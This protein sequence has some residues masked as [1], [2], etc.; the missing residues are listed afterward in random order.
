MLWI[1]AIAVFVFASLIWLSSSRLT[2][3]SRRP[4]Q[5]Y[6]R[7][8]LANAT[9]HGLT[10]R[11][12]TVGSTPCLLC[13]PTPSPGEKGAKLRGEL[14]AAGLTLPAAGE[15]KATIVLLHAHG[16]R[17]ED[18]LPVA[19]RFC[20]VGF[21]CVLPDLP[22][23]GDHPATFATFGHTEVTLPGEVLRAAASQFHFDPAPAGLF[24]V[25]QGG[26]I[27]VQA[28][29]RADEHWFAVAEVAGFAALDDV[30]DGQARRLFGPLH[31]P[32]HW[33]VEQLVQARAGFAPHTIRP[34]DAA[35]KLTIP[36]LVAHG[37]ADDFV[38]PDHAQRLFQAAPASLREFMNIPG[39][40]H[41]NALVTNAP[42]YA[43]VSRF[44]LKALH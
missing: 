19:E 31:Q 6:H 5:D 37:D 43:T 36:L 1:T 11:S 33:L 10:I 38:T 21:R 39:A 42:V 17:K 23:H 9:A 22:G 24:G 12:F 25:S 14:Q 20:A 2:K 3:P 15:M 4:L 18:H 27:A 16:G 29:A 7:D 13:E 35:A 34:V 30:I 40:G 41:G 44:Y 8:I 28:A 26:A 32:A